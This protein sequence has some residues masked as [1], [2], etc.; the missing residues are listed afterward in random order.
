[1]A[2]DFVISVRETVGVF[3]PSNKGFLTLW[4]DFELSQI[5]VGESL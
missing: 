2:R 3:S 4:S 5:L 1:M